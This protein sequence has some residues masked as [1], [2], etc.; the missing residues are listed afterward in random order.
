MTVNK[1]FTGL[2]LATAIS[3]A[4]PVQAANVPAGV[5]LAQKQVLV[6]GNGTEPA[7][8]D[9]Q[10]ME[11]TPGANIAKDLFE[12]LVTQ[13]D[14]GNIIP[15]VAK[16]WDISDDGL[17]Y[18]FHLR[19][20]AKWSNGDPVT[21]DDFVFGFQ[22]AV[23]PKT[24]SP[25]AWYLEIPGIKNVTAI[26]DGKKPVK[27]M[28]VK[29]IDNYTFQV[30]LEKPVAFFIKML[31]HQ[32][33]SPA[34]RSIIET[35]GDQWTSPEHIVSNGA[36]QMDSWVVNEKIVL[37]RNPNYWNNEKT[38]ID[39]VTYLPI[40]SETAALNRY[41]AG[42]MD[43][44][45]TI[46]LD[47]FKKLKKTI[48]DEMKITPQVATYYYVFNTQKVP[49]N[50][51][52][53][54]KALSYAINRDA[55][56]YQVVGQG[57]TP[58]YAFTPEATNGFADPDLAWGKLTQRER[59]AK[60]KKLLKAAGYDH[61]NPLHVKL[62]YNT[63]ESHKKLAIVVSQMWKKALGVEV[64][65]VNE[66]W[67]T[68]LDTKRH[69]NFDVAR[70]GW[71]GDY[72]EPSTMLSV[73]LTGGG[74]NDAK[75]SD[76]EYDDLIAQAMSTQDVVA[77]GQLYAKAENILARDMPEIPVYQYVSSRLVKPYIGGYPMHNAEN[78][79]Y[80]KDLYI[81]KH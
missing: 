9:P 73:W 23:D 12:G 34:H 62:L 72:N 38:V 28:G 57:Q 27:D 69:G 42:E 11:G 15:G 52:R 43:M 58:A 1:L 33:A 8:L 47:H 76:K 17:V 80:T 30:S 51:A 18:T 55:I 20:N 59:L 6:K 16:S 44:T 49:F 50:D 68:F 66:E 70:A 21:A 56:A 31:A 67:K 71:S 81:I 39:Q 19:N 35:W 45:L 40:Q 4:L 54:R 3:A 13:D 60:A 63:S 5:E 14:H 64:E 41:Q 25:Y 32:T 74:N 2:A 10:R 46:P 78:N 26:V 53:V 22:R 48:P 37:K 29:A 77:R 61:D 7:T 65:L 75:W 24:A 36:Y 79:V